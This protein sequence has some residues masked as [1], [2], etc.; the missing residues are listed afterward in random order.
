MLD[1]YLI[2]MKP[3]LNK[4]ILNVE[5]EDTSSEIYNRDYKILTASI[6]KTSN[7]KGHCLHVSI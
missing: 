2:F 3:V 7:L 5:L 6:L 1:P 4:P